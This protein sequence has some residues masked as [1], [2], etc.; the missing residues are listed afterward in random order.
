LP[1]SQPPKTERSRAV[2]I[3]DAMGII[4]LVLL[5]LSAQNLGVSCEKNA[6]S[7]SALLNPIRRVVT[8]LQKMQTQVTEEGKRE[9]ELFEKFEC[10]CKTGSGDLSASISAAQGQI[11]QDTGSLDEAEARS[12]QLKKDLTDHQASRADAKDAVAQAT[13]LRKKEA[14]TF[15]KD[16]SDHT[17]NIAALGSAIAAISKGAAGGSFL[18]TTAAAKLRQLTIDMEISSVDRDA[19]SAFLS[20]HHGQRYIPQS[21]E[22]TGIL[23]QMKDTME[24]DIGDI[25]SVEEQAIADFTSLVGSKTKEIATNTKSIETKTERFG[26]VSVDIVNLEEELDD[27]TKSMRADNKFLANL[28]SSC[29]TK[30]SEWEERSKTRTDELAAL[31]ETIRLLNDDD[32]LELFKKTLPSPSLIQ[33]KTSGR[34]IR[35]Q[36]VK[37]LK[38]GNHQKD[39]RLDL[40][41]IALTGKSSSFDKVLKM[42]DDMIALLGKEQKDDDAKKTF[43]ESELD[44][45]EDQKKVLDQS[46]SDLEKAMDEAQENIATLAS[47][48]KALI[49]GV[50]ALDSSVQDA[51]ENRKAENAEY[52]TTMAANK[53]AKELV[54]VAKKQADAVLQS[55]SVCSTPKN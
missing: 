11:T 2:A 16:D 15:A 7:Q 13:A 4:H 41:M 23:K 26:Q 5:L 19:L 12:V 48:I 25:T 49:A 54:G 51:T 30:K 10:Y 45:T 55:C 50:E 21:G 28:G 47:E 9:K 52:K 6:G 33:M 35:Q 1:Q 37:I 32:S 44:K 38:A 36:A 3:T 20:E 24:K 22:V 53:A 34:A 40:V 17:T 27:T 31:A 14:A 46:L 42:I 8:L 43:C 18:Q 39:P 29:D